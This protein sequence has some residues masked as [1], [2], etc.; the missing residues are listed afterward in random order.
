[1]A[2]SF[3][4]DPFSHHLPAQLV[5]HD[6]P[7]LP[8][9]DGQVLIRFLSAPVNRVDHLVLSGKYPVKPRYAVEGKL[10]PGF[11]G[12]G[13]VL[14]SRSSKFG[15]GDLVLPRELGI[16]TWRTHAV[17]P[18]TTLMKL[19]RGVRPLDA[20]LL[21]SGALVSWLLLEEVAPLSRGDSVIV[22]AGT[23]CVAQFLVQLA[24]RKGVNVILVIRDRED[25]DAVKTKLL[26]L[27]AALVLTETELA[28]E[29]NARFPGKVVL[30]LDSVFGTVGQHLAHSLSP[31]GKYALVGMLAGPAASIT[32]DTTHLFYKQLSFVPFRSSEILKSMGGDEVERLVAKI[33]GFF[34]DGSLKTPE[35][36][37]VSW[38]DRGK[39]EIEEALRQAT[40]M[41]QS[42]QAGYKKTVWL[43]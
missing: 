10:V 19:P 2:R 27:G 15:E 18:D 28:T 24:T 12:C 31:G 39:D 11:D 5:D 34:I 21:R 35:L 36:R 38:D 9:E 16:G 32:V 13:I 8:A 37:A 14:E 43:L 40:E 1:M 22:S 17:L 26:N 41:A 25:I 20:A 7:S 23:S 3:V 33:A 4:H 6:I 29:G 42:K 30:A